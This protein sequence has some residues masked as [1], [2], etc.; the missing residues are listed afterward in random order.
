MKWFSFILSV[1]YLLILLGVWGFVAMDN[2]ARWQMTLFLFSPR[3]AIALPLLVIFPLCLFKSRRSLWIALLSAC[4]IVF[5]LCGLQV[6]F[7]N[8]PDDDNDDNTLSLKLLTCNLGEGAPD[9]DRLVAMA[10]EYQIDVIALQEC[11]WSSS[12]PLFDQLGWQFQ[13]KDNI[14]IGSRFPLGEAEV[15]AQQP[16]S[17]YNAVAAVACELALPSSIG[18]D[19]VSATK[20]LAESTKVEIIAVHLPT[21]RPALEKIRGLDFTAGNEINLLGAEYRMV[22]T[23]IRQRADQFES[24][25]VLAGDFNIPIESYCYKEQ[26]DEYQNAFTAVGK[27]FGFS[28]YTRL[29]GIRIDHVLV[30]PQWKILSAVVEEGLGGDHRPVIV[31]LQLAKSN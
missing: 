5:P 28:K 17:H 27:G 13:Q 1:C 23:A 22:A 31:K 21:F 15:I 20:D 12:T 8:P 29:H 11:S 10:R 19:D 6:H 30:D 18:S 3:W 9:I 14:A 16:P 26:W 7:N 2:G 24:P 4:I 25:T